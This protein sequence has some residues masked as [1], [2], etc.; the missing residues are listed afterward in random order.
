MA[1]IAAETFAS[2][3]LAPLPCETLS[4]AARG[5]TAMTVGMPRMSRPVTS[6][7]RVTP[8]S[9]NSGVMSSS[10]SSGSRTRWV[11]A[12]KTLSISLSQSLAPTRRP[13]SQPVHCERCTGCDE[14][15]RQAAA[16]IIEPKLLSGGAATAAQ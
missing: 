13:E 9:G 2:G 3:R 14:A 12:K 5:R 1:S 16:L 11:P 10:V 4:V 8:K 7:N 15:V 6:A